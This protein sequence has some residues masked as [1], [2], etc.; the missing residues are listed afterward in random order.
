MWYSLFTETL[1][2]LRTFWV[3]D[4]TAYKLLLLLFIHVTV[5]IVAAGT[6]KCLWLAH[7]TCD[8]T[9]TMPMTA[10]YALPWIVSV[11]CVSGCC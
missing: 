1:L 4:S 8:D 10:I 7:I 5:E 2:I 9:F 3:L 6:A 11:H